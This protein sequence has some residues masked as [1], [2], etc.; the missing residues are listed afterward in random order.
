MSALEVLVMKELTTLQ[1]AE[2]RLNRDFAHLRP[3]TKTEQLK[4][5]VGLVRTDQVAVRLE[6]LLEAM[7]SCGYGVVEA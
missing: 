2:A 3:E 1:H 5:V 4:F 7:S 6:R